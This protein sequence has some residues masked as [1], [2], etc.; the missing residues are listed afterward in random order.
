MDKS[1]LAEYLAVTIEICGGRTISKAAKSLMVDRL[2]TYPAK[3]V[4][5]ALLRCQEE[6]KGNCAL[7]DIISRIDDGHPSANE[8]W[9]MLPF[10][11][12]DTCVWTN[13]MRDAW[14]LVN[15]QADETASRMAF[16]D[17]YMRAVQEARNEKR[18]PSWSVSAGTD[19]SRRLKPL[20]E[21]VEK[22]RIN[23]LAA[24]EIEPLLVGMFGDEQDKLLTGATVEDDERMKKI[25]GDSVDSVKLLDGENPTGG[26]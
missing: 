19:A 22:G 10:S 8:A 12:A 1:K 15:R 14:S 7:A 24:I 5:S 16:R 25:I 9:A 3:A 26:C 23:A 17:A 18:G 21:A 2:S 6:V 4:Y 11:E 20:V 13:E